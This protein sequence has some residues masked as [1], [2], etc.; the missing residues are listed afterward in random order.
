[1]CF[2]AAQKEMFTINP[3]RC[4]TI[5]G[6]A[7]W[8]ASV[9]RTNARVEHLVPTPEWL[10]PEWERP[11]ELAV[12]DHAIVAAPD[13]VHQDVNSVGLA[14]YQLERRFGVESMVATD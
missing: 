3:R 10:F 6:A 13:G 4:A 7:S 5:A 2:C 12:V 9:V 8:L 1:M 11:G 14:V